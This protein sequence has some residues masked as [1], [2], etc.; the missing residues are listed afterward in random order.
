MTQRLQLGFVFIIIHM[1]F[2]YLLYPKLTYSLTKSGHWGI[3]LSYGLLQ[4]ILIAIYKKG[5]NY[6]PQKDMID[7]F[8]TMGRWAAFIFLIPY[9]FN[10]NALVAMNI[11][12]H[13]EDIISIFLIRTPYWAV[14]ILLFL[15]ST[16]TAIK[17]LGTILR[18]SA[19]FFFSINLFVIFVIASSTVNFQLQNAL[20][21]WPLSLDFLWNVKFLYL[22]GFSAILFLGFV[23]SETNLKFSQLTAAWLYVLFFY[24]SAVYVPLFIFGQE[25]VTTF[26]FPMKEAADSVDLS[27]FV[28]NRQTLFFGISIIGF[29]LIL[30]AVK[31][32]MIGQIM[33]RLFPG[34]R[35]KASYWILAFS[36]I[37][38]LFALCVP[39]KAWI[40][41]LNLM[42]E[43]TNAFF[44]V[45][46]PSI[47][48]LYVVFSGRMRS[49]G[50]T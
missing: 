41:K 31:L 26:V 3:V 17:G 37:A 19:V 15:I 9:A 12:A 14:L 16:Y 39:N 40:E 10:L 30:N 38:F 22:M 11:R 29:N 45:I 49:Y 35:S 2:G 44:T 25:T 1:S 20:P 50:E 23:P 46:L 18:T 7:I 43:G 5:L 48:F 4:L 8:L 27:W 33:Q 42:S 6:F 13:A 32:W 47:I 34:R 21:A 28:F 24:L 36:F